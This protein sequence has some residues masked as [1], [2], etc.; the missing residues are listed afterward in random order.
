MAP[1][2]EAWPT[3][4]VQ[5]HRGDCAH[6]Q[7]LAPGSP[8]AATGSGRALRGLRRSGPAKTGGVAIAAAQ[9]RP[10]R[11]FAHAC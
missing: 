2:P 7:P 8:F 11:R 6:G 1:S 3:S 9:R 5:R 4:S 10:R